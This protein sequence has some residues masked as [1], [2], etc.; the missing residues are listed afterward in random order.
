MAGVFNDIEL[1]WGGKTYTIKSHRVMG[2][3]AQMEEHITM[4]EMAAYSRRGTAPL[5]RMC[6]AYAAMLKYAGARVTADEVY[7]VA[8]NLPEGQMTVYLTVMQMMIAAT[9]R[10]RQAEFQRRIEAAQAAAEAG[11][12][13]GDVAEPEAEVEADPGNSQA[14]AAAS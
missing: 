5:A 14:A 10:D 13:A 12:A 9:P 6:Q 2:A 3:I 11:E 8:M 4:T 1:V 7:Q